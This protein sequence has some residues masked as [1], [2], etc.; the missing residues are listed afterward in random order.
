M[1]NNSG[2]AKGV[3]FTIGIIGIIY[4][5]NIL[6]TEIGL[7]KLLFVDILA[8]FSIFNIWIGVKKEKD[9]VKDVEFVK[10]F[11]EW[12]KE[13]EYVSYDKLNAELFI[14]NDE[15]EEWV[16]AFEAWMK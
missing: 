12:L 3:L 4:L 9:I 14:Y 7:I 5:H 11:Q 2:F 15:K 8:L 6:Y 10:E 1:E 13:Q 16:N